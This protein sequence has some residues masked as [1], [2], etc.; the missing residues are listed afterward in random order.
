MI[1][2]VVVRLL[3]NTVFLSRQPFR[4]PIQGLDKGKWLSATPHFVLVV[5]K[6]PLDRIAQQGDQLDLRKQTGGPLGC[7]G[8]D[9]IVGS[10]VEGNGAIS[11]AVTVGES[12]PVEPHPLSIVE[13]EVVDLLAQRRHHVGMLDQVVEDRGGAAA[14]CPDDQGGGQS[15]EGC[16][17]L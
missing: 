1:P 5:G 13:I 7:Q 14:L 16:S 11:E 9:Q 12:P 17:E 15:S 2:A 10:G 4:L 6:G 3:P 8:M